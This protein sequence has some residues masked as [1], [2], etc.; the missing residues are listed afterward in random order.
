[1]DLIRVEILYIE[2]IVMHCMMTIKQHCCDAVYIHRAKLSK[3]AVIILK[4]V[5]LELCHD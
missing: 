3:A 5:L 1:M 2:L 4:K